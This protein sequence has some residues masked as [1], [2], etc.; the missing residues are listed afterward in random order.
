[1]GAV[2]PIRER[3]EFRSVN[4]SAARTR[5]LSRPLPEHGVGAGPTDHKLQELVD[6]RVADSV[7]VFTVG[8][9]VTLE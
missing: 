9:D 6:Q 2:F 8:T 7:L 4:K 5:L 3:Q 1:V